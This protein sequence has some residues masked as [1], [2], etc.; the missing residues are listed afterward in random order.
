[1]TALAHAGRVGGGGELRAA[2]SRR[3]RL[4][5]Y[6]LMLPVFALAPVPVLA[7]TVLVTTG[8][9]NAG[10]SI[11]QATL[12]YLAAPAEMRSRIY[13]VLSVC[14]GVGPLGFLY[15]GLLADAIG[16]PAATAISGVLGLVALVV[17]R[18]WWRQLGYP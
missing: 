17:T 9:A 5:P 1:M 15:L 7:G 14:I 10:F 4:A 8:L 6:L 16:A 18:R 12:V 2:R 13:G 11:M 3:R